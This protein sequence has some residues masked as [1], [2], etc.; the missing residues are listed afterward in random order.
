M[1][2]LS[3]QQ[4][5]KLP[6]SEFAGPGRTFPIPDRS[7]AEDAI[8]MAS[9]SYNAGNIS[10][11]TKHTIVAKAQQ[12]LNHRLGLSPRKSSRGR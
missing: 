9:R 3:T 10:K 7:H 6:A 12:A 1:S 2:K 5:S 8:R 4:R 11:H